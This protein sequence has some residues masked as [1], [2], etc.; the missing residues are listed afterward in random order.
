V[1]RIDKSSDNTWI[2][3]A[4][5]A[6]QEAAIFRAVSIGEVSVVFANPDHDYPQE[7]RYRRQGKQL[8]ASIS[9]LNGKD[10]RSFDKIACE[11]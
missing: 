6:G 3:T 8:F 2:F 9:L 10:A 5:P 4:Y 11:Q 7:I 1:L